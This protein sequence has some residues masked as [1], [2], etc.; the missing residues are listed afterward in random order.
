MKVELAT[1]VG[2]KT[3]I[4]QLLWIEKIITFASSRFC[5]ASGFSPSLQKGLN[6]KDVFNYSSK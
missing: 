3:Q 6:K 2:T 4:G 1:L 5:L